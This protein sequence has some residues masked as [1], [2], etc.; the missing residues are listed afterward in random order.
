MK[1]I[2]IKFYF[3]RFTDDDKAVVHGVLTEDNL[4][5]GT[6]STKLD[7]YYIEPARKYANELPPNS[8]IHSIVYKMSD[9]DMTPHNN[10]K[11]R[12]V[13]EEDAEEEADDDENNNHY[14][15]SERLRKKVRNEFKRRRKLEG[16][17]DSNE[18]KDETESPSS[19]IRNKRWL[20]DEVS[21]FIILFLTN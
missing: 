15:A 4:F 18:Q 13:E 11:E 2:L 3:F 7:H 16:N 21:I 8:E 1:L 20:P 14:C 9:I 12:Y 10:K 17:V 5:D 19:R 6:I